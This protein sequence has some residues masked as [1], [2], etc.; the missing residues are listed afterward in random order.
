MNIT[1]I[2]KQTDTVLETGTQNGLIE[3]GDTCEGESQRTA[4]P[5]TGTQDELRLPS[6]HNKGIQ[7]FPRVDESLIQEKMPLTGLRIEPEFQI[8]CPVCGGRIS[9]EHLPNK[10]S[11]IDDGMFYMIET[12]RIINSRITIEHTFDHFFNEEED[13]IR[14]DPHTLGSLI[15]VEFDGTGEC[16]AFSVLKIYAVPGNQE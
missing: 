3:Y 16:I 13:C 5:E 12:D 1:C 15:E 4:A 9:A 11:V 2:K 6:S 10:E 14:I 8:A 7:P